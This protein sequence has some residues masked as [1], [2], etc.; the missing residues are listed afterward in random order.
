MS[1]PS[2]PPSLPR[3]L[4]AQAT[5]SGQTAVAWDLGS[6]GRGGRGKQTLRGAWPVVHSCPARCGFSI[7]PEQSQ[8]CIL[9][10]PKPTPLGAVHGFKPGETRELLWALIMH[11]TFPIPLPPIP[12]TLVQLGGA[13]TSGPDSANNSPAAHKAVTE[14]P[15]QR[16]PW[17]ELPPSARPAQ[18]RKDSTAKPSRKNLLKFNNEHIPLSSILQPIEGL[19]RSFMHD[20]CV[21]IYNSDFNREKIKCPGVTGPLV[22]QGRCSGRA[23]EQRLREESSPGNK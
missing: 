21:I 9:L 10:C 3:V 7:S 16:F 17:P 2:Q 23:P 8:T 20:R 11:P 4:P 19:V 13:P 5:W 6:W 22:E 14:P 12:R 1:A 15:A 18:P